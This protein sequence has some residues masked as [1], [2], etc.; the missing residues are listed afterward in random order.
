[1]DL[2]DF[3]GGVVDLGSAYL[4]AKFGPSSP[5]I[6]SFGMGGPIVADYPALPPP[7]GGSG[8]GLIPPAPPSNGGGG[9][10][11]IPCGP[12]PVYKK[13]CGVYKWVTPKRRRRKMLL[14]PSDAAGLAKLKGIV[15]QGKVMEVWIA[16]HSK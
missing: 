11:G 12:Q 3:F 4:G 7:S 8:G 5:P 13:V 15:G 10:C 14:T 6:T 16:T 9:A 2:G 1:M